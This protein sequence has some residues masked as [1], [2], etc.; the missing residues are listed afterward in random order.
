MFLLYDPEEK[1]FKNF[2]IQDIQLFRE[3]T[4]YT[5]TLRSLIAH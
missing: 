3:E 1:A 4:T 5:R 2:E